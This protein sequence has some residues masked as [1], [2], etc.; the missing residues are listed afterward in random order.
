ME[1]LNGDQMTNLFVHLRLPFQWGL[2]RR[3]AAGQ[4]PTG[5][6]FSIGAGAKRPLQRINSP[7]CPP[8]LFRRVDGD[9]ILKSFVKTQNFILPKIVIFATRLSRP[10]EWGLGSQ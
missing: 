5:Y 3:F 9:S 6:S 7:A 8:T 1:K 4:H 2:D 10:V